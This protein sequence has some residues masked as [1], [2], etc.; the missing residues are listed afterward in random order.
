MRFEPF[1]W[2]EG[3]IL[4]AYACS[5]AIRF[6]GLAGVGFNFNWILFFIYY[7]SIYHGVHLLL[8]IYTRM[9][10]FEFRGNRATCLGM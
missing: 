1:W 5:H 10:N 8:Q 6:L 2:R 9:I 3:G 7:D 4:Q